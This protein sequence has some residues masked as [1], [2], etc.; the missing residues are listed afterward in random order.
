MYNING[1]TIFMVVKK[2]KKLFKFIKNKLTDSYLDTTSN[3]RIICEEKANGEKFYYGQVNA[4][5]VD[6][7]IGWLHLYEISDSV[8]ESGNSKTI[9]KD[10]QYILNLIEQYNKIRNDKIKKL[11]IK[12]TIEYV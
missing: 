3:Y 4:M 11:I 2:M 12:K 7:D 6:G 9:H 1:E 5:I 10:K 8:K